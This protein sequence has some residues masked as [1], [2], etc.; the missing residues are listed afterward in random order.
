MSLPI[1]TREELEKFIANE[2][3]NTAEVMQM[4]DCSRQ[5]VFDLI[6]RGKL[7]PIRESKKET[8]FLKSDIVARLQPSE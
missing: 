7:K 1:T 6:K 5:N 8:L 3:I 4:L 2:L